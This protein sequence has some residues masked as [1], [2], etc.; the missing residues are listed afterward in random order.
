MKTPLILSIDSLLDDPLQ[1]SRP[2]I[3]VRTPLEF[4]EDHLPGA[5]NHPVLGD[6]ERVLV[7]TLAREQGSFQANVQGAALVSAN[8]AAML[9]GPLSDMPRQWN[10]VIYCW[11]GG[12]RSW[13][14]ATVL[15]R[16]G[17][18]V[19]LLDGGYRSYR[20]RAVAD[21]DR[22]TGALAFQVVAG[23]TGTG[24]TRLLQ[25]AAARGAQVLDLEA[26]ANHRGSVLG[27]V[28]DSPQPAQKAF[29]ALLWR[30]LRQFDPGR[31]VL[32]ESESRKIGQL[33]LPESLIARM[34]A[35]P[36]VRIEAE[37][38]VRIRLLRDQYFHLETDRDGFDER[39][40]RL[41]PLYPDHRVSEW[42]TLANAG[43][44][45]RVVQR[46]LQEHYDPTYHRSMRRNYARIADAPAIV[47]TGADDRALDDAAGRLLL[48]LALDRGA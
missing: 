26:L 28:P 31:P 12:S 6:H 2:L 25:L 7:G 44:W 30:I 16:V 1:R 20:Q 34:R 38:D 5:A 42:R 48:E 24:K 11:R 10:P 29:D 41:M 36:C 19:A 17:W 33:H 45:D 22:L 8:I 46:L 23:P 40:E 3:D 37:M 13:S 27:A 4:A 35:S 21:I 14:L 18:R 47:L 9:A 15:A 32:V 43:D 39:L